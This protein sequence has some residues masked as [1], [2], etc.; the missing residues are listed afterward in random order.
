MLL[1][2][3]PLSGVIGRSPSGNPSRTVPGEPAP[4]T[5]AK[6]FAHAQPEPDGQHCLYLPFIPIPPAQ[7][8]AR[9]SPIGLALLSLAIPTNH[10]ESISLSRTP[11]IQ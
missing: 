6:G 11:F 2:K 8:G 9:G 5:H 1:L 3:L 4:R 7:Q 10:R